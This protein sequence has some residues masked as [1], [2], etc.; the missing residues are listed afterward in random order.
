M[1]SYISAKSTA[2]PFLQLQATS[3]LLKN[4]ELVYQETL[5]FS[6]FAPIMSSFDEF[7]L[8]CKSN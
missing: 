7:K 2:F 3:I 8:E 4:L 6:L 5:L 1:I